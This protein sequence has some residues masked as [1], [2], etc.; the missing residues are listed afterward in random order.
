MTHLYV[1]QRSDAPQFGKVGR[2]DD[3]VKRAEA[4]QSGHCFFVR[5]LA[6]CSDVG[7][8]ERWVHEQL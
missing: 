6:I 4:L 7:H 3:P 5:V 2:S 1:M 8:H